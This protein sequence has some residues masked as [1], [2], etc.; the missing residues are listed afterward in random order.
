MAANWRE[1]HRQ[2]DEEARASPV[3]GILIRALP[4]LLPAALAG[5]SAAWAVLRQAPVTSVVA[6]GLGV[7]A[8]GATAVAAVRAARRWRL[9]RRRRHAVQ[10]LYERPERS[11]APE[12]ITEPRRGRP[13]PPAT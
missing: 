4:L 2:D 12:R 3:V 7:A 1:L 5:A 13:R 11:R 10:V 6:G 8:A 9:G